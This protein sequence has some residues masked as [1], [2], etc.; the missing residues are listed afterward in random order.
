MQ[1]WFPDAFIR[2][3]FVMTSDWGR[4]VLA[5]SWSQRET[6]HNNSI[7][8]TGHP[9]I[10]K[11]PALEWHPHH[12]DVVEAEIEMVYVDGDSPKVCRNIIQVIDL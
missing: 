9:V 2:L 5:R 1:R 8:K 7:S 3:K 10:L 12:T 4:H 6:I 11:Q